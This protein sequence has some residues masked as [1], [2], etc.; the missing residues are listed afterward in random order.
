MRIFI[1]L[2]FLAIFHLANAKDLCLCCGTDILSQD[3]G[4]C[5]LLVTPLVQE[6]VMMLQKLC[7]TEHSKLVVDEYY[8]SYER[9]YYEYIPYL[10][11]ES[12]AITIR[13][14]FYFEDC[15]KDIDNIAS[16][17]YWIKNASSNF[18]YNLNGNYLARK[19]AKIGHGERIS[20]LGRYRYDRHAWDARF[21]PYRLDGYPDISAFEGAYEFLVRRLPLSYEVSNTQKVRQITWDLQEEHLGVFTYHNPSPYPQKFA[22]EVSFPSDITY[23]TEEYL[24]PGTLLKYKGSNE[25]FTLKT[26]EFI[27][28]TLNYTV[29]FNITIEP[30]RTVSAKVIGV[31][32]KVENVFTATLNTTF[33]QLGSFAEYEVKENVTGTKINIRFGR[34]YLSEIQEINS[35]DYIVISYKAIGNILFVVAFLLVLLLLFIIVRRIKKCCTKKPSPEGYTVLN[36]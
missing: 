32:T 36:E 4:N 35:D 23:E 30:H 21:T 2:A 28:Q 27:S 1:G 15:K 22:I 29:T 13:P 16:M 12:W 14:D 3:T 20:Q 24:V 5:S 18:L 7:E 19:V 10:A 34:F 9:S 17:L 31:W 11:A 33:L 26:G 6:D 25:T 8:G